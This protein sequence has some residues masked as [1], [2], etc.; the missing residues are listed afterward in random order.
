[1][2][3]TVVVD[4]G[5]FAEFPALFIMRSNRNIQF[6]G[7]WSKIQDM[8]DAD[9]TPEDMLQSTPEVLTLERSV[10]NMM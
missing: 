9:K 6:V 8:M 5:G 7:N 3:L 1:M 2:L 4:R 10:R